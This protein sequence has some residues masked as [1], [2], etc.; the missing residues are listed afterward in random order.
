[1]LYFY[2]YLNSSHMNNQKLSVNCNTWTD[3]GL[4]IKIYFT[5]YILV[6]N[7]SHDCAKVS[8]VWKSKS[9]INEGYFYIKTIHFVNI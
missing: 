2:Y 4:L 9:V 3:T 5:R 7:I 8:L 6:P 1:M